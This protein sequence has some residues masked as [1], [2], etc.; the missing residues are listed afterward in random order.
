LARQKH[1][2]WNGYFGNDLP[3]EGVL[4]AANLIGGYWLVVRE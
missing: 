4:K 1:G 3:G 2:I